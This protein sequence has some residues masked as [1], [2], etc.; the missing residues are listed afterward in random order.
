MVKDMKQVWEDAK[1]YARENENQ[2]LSNMSG[3]MTGYRVGYEE[4]TKESEELLKKAIYTASARLK[5]TNELSVQHQLEDEN[6]KLSNEVDKWKEC[7]EN[8][9]NYLKAKMNDSPTIDKSHPVHD[10]IR[11]YEQLKQEIP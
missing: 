5:Y 10:L 2:N 1:K 4:G 3:L 9:Y 11:E 7:A 6:Y 8:M